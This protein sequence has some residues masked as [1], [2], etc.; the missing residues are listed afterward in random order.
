MDLTIVNVCF[1]LFSRFVY[2]TK[3]R[4]KGEEETKEGQGNFTFPAFLE[5][6]FITC[7]DGTAEA[8]R[9]ACYACHTQVPFLKKGIQ[10]SSAAA[11]S[12]CMAFVYSSLNPSPKMLEVCRFQTKPWTGTLALQVLSQLLNL[13]V[14]VGLRCVRVMLPEASN[15]LGSLHLHLRDERH[16]GVQVHK[17]SSVPDVHL[18]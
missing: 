5:A 18:L 2:L 4:K 6:F 17:E 16:P 14:V 10:H 12:A 1:P 15:Y 3:R 9:A 11:T 8:T 13:W 7:R